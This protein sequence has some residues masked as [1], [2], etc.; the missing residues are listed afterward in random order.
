MHFVAYQRPNA[1]V[2]GVSKHRILLKGEPLQRRIS[3][4]ITKNPPTIIDIPFFYTYCM[5]YN[6]ILIVVLKI[7]PYN[8]YWLDANPGVFMFD[9]R[10]IRQVIYRMHT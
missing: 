2:A 7:P 8:G 4:R 1:N 9:R 3:T 10:G 6:A 5:R